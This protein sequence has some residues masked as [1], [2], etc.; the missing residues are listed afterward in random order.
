MWPWR[1]WVIA[2]FNAH[3]PYDQ[4]VTEQL[5]GDLL[6]N[7]TPQQKLAT[8]FNRNHRTVTEAGSIEEEWLVENVVDRVETTWTA[9][10]GLTI[11]C[12]RCHDHKFDPISQREFYQFFAFFNNVDEKGVYTE[13]RG[14]VPPLMTIRSAEDERRLDEFNRTVARLEE[15]IRGHKPAIE[16]TFEGWRTQLAQPQEAPAASV[17]IPLER[18]A[19]ARTADGKEVGPANGMGLPA[20]NADSAALAATFKGN[21]VVEYADLVELDARTPFSFSA[22]VKLDGQG[23]LFSQ[24]DD[25]ADFRGA[26]LT[27]LE[28]DRLACH[29]IHRWPDE[30]IKVIVRE[31]PPKH[32]WIHVAVTYDG[33]SNACGVKL[34]V[35]GKPAAVDVERDSLRHNFSVAQPLRLG[36]RLVERPLQGELRGATFFAEAL[37][38][39]AIPEVISSNLATL[40]A[41]GESLDDRAWH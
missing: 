16:K 18:D 12:A 26:D 37:A 35:N 11:G 29:L 14:N 31:R 21:E 40:N 23:A 24:M 13:Q 33:S 6:P 9:V 8:G 10:L 25:R 7:A 4:F 28:D 1:D 20:F 38:G 41:R 3:M 30:S 2:A 39:K 32:K 17:S 27:V 15:K 22:F 36:R 19:I 5:A 34:Y